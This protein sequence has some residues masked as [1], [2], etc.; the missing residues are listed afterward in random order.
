MNCLVWLLVLLSLSLSWKSVICLHQAALII[1]IM[2]VSFTL[3]KLN[4]PSLY[5][6]DCWHIFTNDSSL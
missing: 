5:L 4:L 3:N 1:F 2:S 6:V